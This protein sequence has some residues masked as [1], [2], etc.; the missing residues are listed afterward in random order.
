[1]FRNRGSFFQKCR[2]HF[3]SSLLHCGFGAEGGL[4]SGPQPEVPA[5]D[6]RDTPPLAASPIAWS[7]AQLALATPGLRADT[8][9]LAEEVVAAEE[10]R[11]RPRIPR[12]R[13]RRRPV[14]RQLL[15]WLTR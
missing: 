4:D 5:D 15:R 9:E 12:Q 3:E 8:R 11:N 2:N 14:R 6:E 10:A 1:M 7:V 13:Q